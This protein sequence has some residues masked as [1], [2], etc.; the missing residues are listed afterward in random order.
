MNIGIG[1]SYMVPPQLTLY[2]YCLVCIIAMKIPII[3]FSDCWQRIESWWAQ[4]R[5]FRCDWWIDLC[6]VSTCIAVCPS[7]L[8]FWSS[9][10]ILQ[11]LVSDGI[12]DG[13]NTIHK[14]GT[15]CMYYSIDSVE[16]VIISY[17]RAVFQRDNYIIVVIFYVYVLHLCS[18]HFT[19]NRT[20]LLVFH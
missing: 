20:Y 19:T 18:L 2:V 17:A 13:N 6:N 15:F 1:V 7:C 11:G 14:H 5:R 16:T 9:I 8:T 10:F 4:W 12:F 3:I